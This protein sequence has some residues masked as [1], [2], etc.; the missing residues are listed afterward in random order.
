MYIASKS[1]HLPHY[2]A[3]RKLIY[4]NNFR[5]TH[6]TFQSIQKLANSL[7]LQIQFCKCNQAMKLDPLKSSWR[8]LNQHKIEW[9]SGWSLRDTC[10]MKNLLSNHQLTW[11]KW[12]INK[13]WTEYV[14]EDILSTLFGRFFIHFV[15]DIYFLLI[16]VRLA[17]KSINLSSIVWRTK[18]LLKWH[19]Q[20]NNKDWSNKS[21]TIKNA[22]INARIK[23][24]LQ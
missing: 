19:I 2:Y 1:L 6:A 17:K 13:K 22:V 12:N 23:I 14:L 16:L 15:W 18:T 7:I 21:L 11:I 20:D 24:E 3:P 8:K 9:I 5:A 4:R 10:D